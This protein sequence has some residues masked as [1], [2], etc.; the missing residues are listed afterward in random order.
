LSATE[1][2]TGKDEKEKMTNF[3]TQQKAETVIKAIFIYKLK[4]EENFHKEIETEM[5]N[6]KDA[7]EKVLDPQVYPK[8]DGK[9]TRTAIVEYLFQRKTGQAH[10]FAAVQENKEKSPKEQT[11]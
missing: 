5:E 9:F 6:K 10:Q 11:H 7:S 2:P 3:L 8:K 4:K 1:Q